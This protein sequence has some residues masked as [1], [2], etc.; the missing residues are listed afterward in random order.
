MYEITAV[1]PVRRGS[2]RVRN[3]NTKLFAGSSLLQKKIDLLKELPIKKIII[4]TDCPIAIKAAEVNHIEYVL[5]DPYYASSKCTGSEFHEYLAR[6]TEAE[7][8]LVA[9]V[10]EPLVSKQSFLEAFEIF[11]S[12]QY[13]SL[14]SVEIVKKFL[15]FNNAPLNYSVDKAPTSQNLP[16]YFSPT[17]GIALVKRDAMLRTKHLICNK[18]YFY[19]L[20]ELEAVD[21][22]TE[23]DFEFAEFLY[24]KYRK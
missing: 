21:V 15:W 14:I 3:K 10:T 4:N 17:F 20:D 19:K 24:N 22:D 9:H 7:N 23:L 6:V 8:I 5:R 16:E 2:Q 11:D 1:I 12:G 18:P 13:D